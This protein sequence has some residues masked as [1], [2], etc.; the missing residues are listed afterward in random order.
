MEQSVDVDGALLQLVQ[1][2]HLL[3]V[4]RGVRFGQIISRESA[5]TRAPETVVHVAERSSRAGELHQ[6]RT[7]REHQ[8]DRRR[9][10]L[11]CN[12]VA[13]REP[14]AGAPEVNLLMAASERSCG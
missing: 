8:G 4:D 14:T 13:E 1:G 11:Y 6:C 7:A 12:A 10:G 5:S 9:S 3:G 2:G